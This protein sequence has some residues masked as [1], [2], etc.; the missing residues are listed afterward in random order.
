[1]KV[2]S[3]ILIAAGIGVLIGV[4]ATVLVLFVAMPSMMIKTYE[5]SYSYDETIERLQERIDNAGWVVSGISRLNDSLSKH[6]VDL[7]P[8]VTLLSLCHPEYAK[9]VLAT[10]RY[11]SVMM[12][13]KFSIW[14]GDDGKAYLTKM[15]MGLMGKLFG[16]NIAEVMGGRVAV[17][18]EQILEGLLKK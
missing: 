11:I 5:T 1:M 16:G 4:L 13:C 9:S 18:E 17:D 2:R 3:N 6:G 7:K 8:R 10:D 12:P 14:E 15:N